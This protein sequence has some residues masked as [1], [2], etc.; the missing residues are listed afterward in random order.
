[1]TTCQEFQALIDLAGPATEP[2]RESLDRH[3]QA[4]AACRDYQLQAARVARLLGVAP[5]AVEPHA[6]DRIHR[7]LRADAVAA[8]RQSAIALTGGLLALFAM[9]WFATL[10]TGT[11]VGMVILAAWVLLLGWRAQR[12]SR[13]ALQFL[14]ASTHPTGDLFSIWQAE[15]AWR[16]RAIRWGGPWLLLE[17]SLISSAVILQTDTADVR[18]LVFLLAALATVGLV[19]QQLLIELPALR[20]EARLLQGAAE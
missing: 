5:A 2:P 9:V 18:L 1:M 8:R 4:C 6:L 13:R 11:L 17:C 15:L 20:R 14:A 7:R 3:L 10:G 12:A 16:I 19:I